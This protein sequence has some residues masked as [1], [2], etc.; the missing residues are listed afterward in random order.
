MKWK[1][2]TFFNA[3][4]VGLFILLFWCSWTSLAQ[5]SSTPSTTTPPDTKLNR[6][7]NFF[8]QGHDSP[9]VDPVDVTPQWIEKLAVDFP[10][11]KYQWLGNE[12]WKY[13]ASLVYIILAFYTSKFLDHLT[14]VWLR[15]W[16]EKTETKFDDLILDLLNGPVKVV[17]FVVFLHIGLSVF[18]WPTVVENILAKCFTIVV[19]STLTY[20]L[21]KFVEL[22]LGYWRQRAS[23]DAD[24]T[25][26][27]QLFPIIRKS[28]KVFIVVVA[29][30]VTCQNLGINVTAAITSLSIGGLAIGLAAQ[31][32]L[33]NLFGAIAVFVD[34][35]FRIGDTIRIDQ[36]EGNVE[37]IGMR[38][39]RVR[40]AK[41]FLITIP[42]KTV[43][44]ATIT[45]ITGRP[46][47][48]TEMNIGL[49]YDTPTE[50]VR[51]A[52]RIIEEVYRSNPMTKDLVVNF[53]RF[54]D[55]A[56]NINVVHFW[57]SSDNKAYLAGMQEMNL[58][59]KERFDKEGINFALPTQTLMLKQD[60]DGR[61]LERQSS[62]EVMA[63]PGS[64]PTG[65]PA[66][67]V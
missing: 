37:S 67:Q 27:E 40:N 45:N 66:P 9:P 16:A 32:T 30:L 62:N 61:M 44:N 33:A 22:A 53:N 48:Q 36:V 17:S 5:S 8:T 26:D 4:L 23:T 55:S 34:K 39:T 54:A 63:L 59:L 7:L 12:L 43:G 3:L 52:L 50:K 6:F 20:M 46:T 35:P 18:R 49:T 31:D 65:P 57:G 2:Q 64:G 19:A 14:R 29:V 51:Q 28:L 21:V 60:S 42:N 58:A 38:S 1:F 10:F 41:G 56:L 15:K 47:I 11:L 25:F 24:R 13:M